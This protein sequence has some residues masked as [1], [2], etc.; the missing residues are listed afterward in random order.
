MAT[1]MPNGKATMVTATMNLTVAVSLAAEA[2]VVACAV[3]A[4]SHVTEMMAAAPGVT[5]GVCTPGIAGEMAAAGE[6]G[7][8][9]STGMSAKTMAH[10]RCTEA[11]AAGM[12]HRGARMEAA[13][14]KAAAAHATAGKSARAATIAA[15]VG[16]DRSG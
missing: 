7:P 16:W 11:H 14:L 13:A 6:M 10:A 3:P 8:A 12:A 2:G 5:D 15:C 4:T 9:N 1:T